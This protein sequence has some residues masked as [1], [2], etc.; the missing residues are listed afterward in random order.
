M[1][2]WWERPVLTG[3]HVCLEPL[4]ELHAEGYL[5]AAS[6]D[7]AETFR[8]L[9]TASGLPR[10]V[11]DASTDIAAAEMAAERQQRIAWAQIDTRT[12]EFA[13]TTSYYE[14]NPT[15]R[16]LAIGHTWLGRRWWGTAINTEAKLLLLT[17]AFDDLGAVRVVW[18]T[19]ANNERSQ[20]AI[21]RLG[22]TREGE[23]RKH[24]QRRDGT[25]RTTVQYAMT[26]DDWP[27]AHV[28]LN[29]RLRG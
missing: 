27:A 13:G 4:T 22:A 15:T 26:D 9:N 8:W 29:E 10:T 2:D 23:L 7:V 21:E 14:I 25:W 18:H 24:K 5:G 16:S 12:G 20:R 19:D 6:D 17:R 3:T 11:D 28:R 1:T